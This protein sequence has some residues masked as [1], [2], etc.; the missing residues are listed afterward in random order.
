[1]RG[2]PIGSQVLKG[3]LISE[4][5]AMLTPNP[6]LWESIISFPKTVFGIVASCAGS[7][8]MSRGPSV[9]VDSRH[10]SSV[11]GT[12]RT[13]RMSVGR[14]RNGNRYPNPPKEFNTTSANDVRQMVWRSPIAAPVPA[15]P[16]AN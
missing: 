7:E 13:S 1:M 9:L 16:T 8:G 4:I 15:A 3:S 10:G 5:G 14:R 6:A 2:N 11:D 12:R